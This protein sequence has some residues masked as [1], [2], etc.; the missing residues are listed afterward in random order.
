M[1]ICVIGA[2]IMG[3]TI[4]YELSCRGHAVTIMEKDG[5]FAGASHRSFAW[6][7]ANNKQPASY[8]RLNSLAVQEHR[9]FQDDF[10]SNTR[11]L[12]MSGNLLVDFSE[13][14]PHTYSE[15]MQDAKHYGSTVY[16][17]DREQLGER[18]PAVDW[19]P[20]VDGALFFPD[21]GY[22]E[23]DLLREELLTQLHAQ[24][25]EIQRSIVEKVTS[26]SRGASVHTSVGEHNFDQVV[27][28]AGAGSSVLA[29][30]S[31]FRIP[32]ADLSQPSPR[33][34]SLLGL[35]EM[36]DVELTHVI[37][38][39]QINVRPRHDG[40]IWV[41]VP[42]VEHRVVEGESSALLEEIRAVM[43]DELVR[44]FRTQVA[45]DRVFFS[46][47]SFPE[48]GRSIVGHV[49]DAQ[50]VYAAV[51]HSGMTLAPLIARLTA[52]ELDGKASPLLKDFR[53]SRFMHGIERVRE[54]NV[55]GRQ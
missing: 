40:R 52:E 26:T 24:K 42:T 1:R 54:P 43:E 37:I 12:S 6:I 55:I 5:P 8:H 14:R 27:I 9:R 19:P 16:A 25:V 32:L 50:R 10:P 17:L 39:N 22:L 35:S 46:G 18:E 31:G 2:G 21:E 41:Q 38:S 23:N 7:N 47:R 33:T 3:L 29:Q 36:T 30:Q 51:T 34:H 45:I 13:N 11:W 44:L 48:D 4:A 15:R 53:P 49:D 20:D 28:A